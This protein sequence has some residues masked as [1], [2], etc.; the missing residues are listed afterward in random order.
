MYSFVHWIFIV[1]YY[2]YVQWHN[3]L[4][5]FVF[6]FMREKKIIVSVCIIDNSCTV[7]NNPGHV[8]WV[9][10]KLMTLIFARVTTF[11]RTCRRFNKKKNQHCEIIRK[12]RKDVKFL[13]GK[14]LKNLSIINQKNFQNL[15]LRTVCHNIFSF[16]LF[17]I[18]NFFKQTNPWLNYWL[19]K[20]GPEF[21]HS[22]K[23]KNVFICV[24]IFSLLISLVS[25]TL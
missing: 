19:Q 12:N 11:I 15:L 1:L 13:E 8:S 16:W 25:H 4:I 5:I 21:I 3:K 7:R 6:H 14:Q 2:L 24:S 20:L 17:L 22:L 9:V 23:F 18:K 10:H